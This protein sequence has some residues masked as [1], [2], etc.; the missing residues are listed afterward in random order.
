MNFKYK[1]DDKLNFRLKESVTSLNNKNDE[2]V[3]SKYSNENFTFSNNSI[4]TGNAYHLV[5][6]VLDFKKISSMAELNQEI[7]N[8]LDILKDAIVLVDKE[9]LL[10]NIILLRKFTDNGVV[11]KEKE[12]IMKDKISNLL[13]N[14]SLDDEILVQG[15]IDLFIV[16]NN[17][18]IL[19]DYKYSNSNS[20]KYLIE[21]YKNQIK[22]YKKA[23]E[24]AQN[25]KVGASFLLSLRNNKLIQIDK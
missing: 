25:L 6:K 8:N 20:E 2:D 14:V 13:E 17:E 18:I 12:F 15:V 11:F 23:L 1:I 21:K 19:I 10:K 3:L 24:N 4:E 7:D 5:L 9:I 22:L 16:T